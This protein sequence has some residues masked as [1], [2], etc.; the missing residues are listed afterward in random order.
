MQDG[1]VGIISSDYCHLCTCIYCIYV[2]Y[3]HLRHALALDE[4]GYRPPTAAAAAAASG[5]R[6]APRSEVVAVVCVCVRVRRQLSLAVLF[7][8]SL[9]VCLHAGIEGLYEAI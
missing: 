5:C 6:H 8:L 3:T 4:V 1:Q 9:R 2:L 7:M